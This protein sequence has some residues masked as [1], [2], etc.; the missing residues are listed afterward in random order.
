MRFGSWKCS[1]QS[2]KQM[3]RH[4]PAYH[5]ALLL[6]LLHYFT[7]KL[8][9]FCVFS[10]LPSA[11]SAFL[12]IF[13][14]FC[15]HAAAA[16]QFL[17]AFVLI[18]KLWQRRNE[19]RQAGKKTDEWGVKIMSNLA[20]LFLHSWASAHPCDEVGNMDMHASHSELT[21]NEKSSITRL[22]QLG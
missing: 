16:I 17:F 21:D 3:S 10:V 8:Q 19:A 5:S 2:W 6:S 13:L 11:L 9:C 7:G 1:S 14:R 15:H 22:E 20:R 4:P 12:W 18:T